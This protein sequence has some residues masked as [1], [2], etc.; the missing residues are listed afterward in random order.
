MIKTAPNGRKLETARKYCNDYT[1]TQYGEV[2]QTCGQPFSWH[3]GRMRHVEPKVNSMSKSISIGKIAEYRG[4][5]IFSIT[6]QSH[7]N[8]EFG[9][10]SSI[11]TSSS[12]YMLCSRDVPS[13]N[14]LCLDVRGLSEEDDN[15]VLV[16]APKT[17]EKIKEACD[18]YNRSNLTSA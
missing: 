11:F 13:V 3:T 14:F 17:F 18:E 8:E 4:Q 12:G 1:Y 6:Y 7:R 9:N 10:N 2:C 16:T 5:I 15:K